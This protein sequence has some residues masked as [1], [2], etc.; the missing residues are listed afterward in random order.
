MTDTPRFTLR[1]LP[2]PAKLVVTVFLLSVG[3]GYF[4]ALVQI[5]FQHSDK[6]GE[7]MPTPANVVAVFAGK[8]WDAGGGPAPV[9]RLESL[10]S[11]PKTGALTSS[12]M[13]PAFFDKDEAYKQEI[14]KRP[15]AEVDAER[16]AE[17]LAV[18]AWSKL[19]PDARK[20]AY[21][22]DRAEGPEFGG[23]AVK[24]KTIL[25]AR[26]ETCH[27]AGGDKSDIP[28][29]TYDALDKLMKVGAAAPPGG[30]WVD[31]GKQIGLVKLTQSTHAHLL[32]FS[33][34][35]SLTGLVFAFTSYPTVARCVL[36]PLVLLAQVADVSCWWLAR[37]DAPYGPYF[38]YCILGT[39]G[40]VGMGLAAQI[41]LSVFAMYGR[42]GKVGVLLVF[43]VGGAV[44]G[45]VMLKVVKPYLD[46]EKADAAAQ[47]APKP[48]EKPADPPA[49]GAGVWGQ[50]LLTGQFKPGGVWNGK[51]EGGMVR[52]FF[53][54]DQDFR[55]ALK[56]KAPELPTL[57]AER[58]T[59][60]ALAEA[61]FGLPDDA[62]KR[63]YAA[64][65]LPIPAALA[66]KPLTAKYKAG[67]AAKVK[68]LL[69]D[70]CV[71]C[72][73]PGGERES[74]PLETYEQFQKY[75]GP[76][77]ATKAAPPGGD[78]IPTAGD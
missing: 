38:A 31:S 66:D 13:T 9:S 30:G 34:L 48:A 24:I 67:A 42:K 36:S 25:K 41:V 21:D 63:A 74:N 52:A 75:F 15:R 70:R 59:E 3:V 73:S 14:K 32:S 39:G 8:K 64:D 43:L 62:R 19:A 33:M 44:G 77:P 16:E 26:C 27:A 10:V 4:S 60:R 2:L 50:K 58:E 17:R 51:A 68:T 61:W 1:D 12:N 45:L 71:V 7:A 28:L 29:D 20:A 23:K 69:A 72:H 46:K 65:S 6:N 37:L 47:P 35:F 56:E 53:D 22:A 76:P 57:Q 11:G 5:H 49:V 78:K 54:K 18:V 55:D 40:V